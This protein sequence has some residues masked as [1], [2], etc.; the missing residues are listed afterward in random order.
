MMASVDAT[1]HLRL[2]HH[3]ARKVARTWTLIEYEDLVGWG[4]LGLV[5]A[6]ERWTPLRGCEFSTYAT[7]RIRGQMMDAVEKELRMTQ[8]RV[9]MRNEELIPDTRCTATEAVTVE[10]DVAS[11]LAQLSPR[12]AS[13]MTMIYLNGRTLREIGEMFELTESRICQIRQESI[14]KLRAASR[15][16]REGVTP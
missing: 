4:M 7:Y 5:K 11:L 9:P 12:N 2:V 16:R 8:R 14:T 6:S 1:Q 13:I 15:R 10:V 3:I